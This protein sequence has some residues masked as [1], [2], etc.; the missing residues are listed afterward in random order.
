MAKAKLTPQQEK[1]QLENYLA[2]LQ[3]RL[4]SKNYKAA[5]TPEEYEK[6]KEQHKKAKLRYKF[7]K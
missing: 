3:K 7:M 1:K 2:F 4:D 6:T 5:V